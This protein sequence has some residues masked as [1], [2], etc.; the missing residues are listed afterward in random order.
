[1]I[2]QI[3]LFFLRHTFS[4]NHKTNIIEFTG[5]YEIL[6]VSKSEIIDTNG[7][8]DCFAGGFLAYYMK[9]FAVHQCIEAGHWAAAQILRRRGCDI[10][11]EIETRFSLK[12]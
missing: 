4:L 11:Y 5:S 7:A 3:D 1:M 9:G 8:G 12:S 2:I 6:F 10:P